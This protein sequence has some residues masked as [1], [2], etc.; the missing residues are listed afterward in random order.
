[1][2]TF[3]SIDE[4]TQFFLSMLNKLTGYSP[5]DEFF[6]DSKTSFLKRLRDQSLYLLWAESVLYNGE[7]VLFC[8]TSCAGKSTMAAEFSKNPGAVLFSK[9]T[10]WAYLSQ[11]EHPIIFNNFY[12]PN[13]GDIVKASLEWIVYLTDPEFSDKVKP[14]VSRG[15]KKMILDHL[16]DMYPKSVINK[17]NQ[18]NFFEYNRI[19]EEGNPTASYRRIKDF[20]DSHS[21]AP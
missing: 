7:G 14:G 15:S 18:L 21:K 12:N 11:D 17:L 9:A 5:L 8:G 2:P 20:I 13:G 10:T 6:M 19:L 16:L 3:E 1:M 4:A